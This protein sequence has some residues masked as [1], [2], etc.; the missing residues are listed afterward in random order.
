MFYTATTGELLFEILFQK[1]AF[2]FSAEGIG[3]YGSTSGVM[4]VLSMVVL[5]RALARL[6]GRPLPDLAWVEVRLDWSPSLGFPC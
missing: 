1:K 6:V 3:F 5:P 4:M 2:H